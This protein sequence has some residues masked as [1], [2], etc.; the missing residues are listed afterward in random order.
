MKKI[1]KF[2]YFIFDN[3]TI[4]KLNKELQEYLNEKFTEILN[5]EARV[6]DG[7]DESYINDII[8]IFNNEKIQ[9]NETEKNKIFF[10][11]NLLLILKQ[12]NKNLIVISNF[13]SLILNPYLENDMKRLDNNLKKKN[14][15]T[16]DLFV[17]NDKNKELNLMENI[18]FIEKLKKDVESLDGNN[19]NNN[20]IIL[21]LLS[22][23]LRTNKIDLSYIEENINIDIIKKLIDIIDD[24]DSKKMVCYFLSIYYQKKNNIDYEIYWLH[25]YICY[26]YNF[27]DYF[28]YK[29]IKKI[30]FIDVNF[31]QNIKNYLLSKVNKGKIDFKN[32]VNLN[33]V[34]K[35]KLNQNF[36]LN[37]KDINLRIVEGIKVDSMDKNFLNKYYIGGNLDISKEIKIKDITEFLELKKITR[38][39]KSYGTETNMSVKSKF[40]LNLFFIYD[41][42]NKILYPR[43]KYKNT[44]LNLK[45]NLIKEGINIYYQSNKDKELKNTN[46]P[47]IIIL[48]SDILSE[49][50]ILEYF[51]I[52]NCNQIIIK[53]NENHYQI[54]NIDFGIT[55]NIYENGESYTIY[56][57][58]YEVI[59]NFEKENFW[60]KNIEGCYLLRKNNKNYILSLFLIDYTN[61][62]FTKINK[63]LTLNENNI[64]EIHR[65]DIV[66]IHYLNNH[67]IF[68][69]TNCAIY[70]YLIKCIIYNRSDI[71]LKLYDN[72]LNFV[73]RTNLDMIL[74]DFDK[75]DIDL[76]LE[77]KNDSKIILS[78]YKENIQYVDTS[79]FTLEDVNN[80]NIFSINAFGLFVEFMLNEDYHF[81]FKNY[82]LSLSYLLLEKINKDISTIQYHEQIIGKTEYY[83]N[84]S[85]DYLLNLKNIKLP[86]FL[87]LINIKNEVP[88]L[89]NY[90]YSSYKKN[91]LKTV[92]IL[93][94]ESNYFSNNEIYYSDNE[95]SDYI[96]KDKKAKNEISLFYN[97]IKFNLKIDLKINYKKLPDRTIFN[98]TLLD[99]YFKE[100]F[101]LNYISRKN[102]SNNI[103][104]SIED[105][106]RLLDLLDLSKLESSESK[107]Y[108]S[109]HELIENEKIYNDFIKN[110]K[111]IE[112]YQYK[113]NKNALKKKIK[114]I[115]E[116]INKEFSDLKN[117]FS[118]RNLYYNNYELNHI[119]INYN[120]FI[121]S[122]L[123]DTLINL[124][125]I[126]TL[127]R[128]L[129]IILN[130]LNLL[131]SNPNNKFIIYNLVSNCFQLK[132]K[133]NKEN[134]INF[135]RF[136]FELYFGFI[137]KKDQLNIL[138]NIEYN[139]KNDKRK[140]YQ[141]IMGQGKS[142]VIVPYLLNHI[143]NNEINKIII[144]TLQ[145]LI[146]QTK[147]KLYQVLGLY[148]N[149]LNNVQVVSD[150]HLKNLYIQNKLKN[151]KISH[152]K[153]LIIYDEIDNMSNS[154]QSDYNVII[155][156][157]EIS[158]INYR[159][160]FIRKFI[161]N[162]YIS[163]EY[164]EDRNELYKNNLI[165]NTKF[166]FYVKKYNDQI[167]KFIEKIM[168]ETFN[169][170]F[171]NLKEKIDYYKLIE[172][173]DEQLKK[174][175]IDEKE[176]ILIKRFLIRY[177]NNIIPKFINLI[178]NKDFG[179][180]VTLDPD[181]YS[182]IHH[183]KITNNFK[184]F[185]GVVPYDY[186]NT[187]TKKS[188]FN[189]IDL[190]IS[191]ISIIYFTEDIHCKLKTL[192]VS[193]LKSD[194]NTNNAINK[195]LNI[196]FETKEEK[197]FNEMFDTDEKI[198]SNYNPENLKV[199]DK[200]IL[201]KFLII[202]ICKL[203]LKFKSEQFN[204]SFNE[205]I[206]SRYSKYQ[207][208][209]T[210]TPNL[211]LPIDYTD[212]EIDDVYITEGN[213]GLIVNAVL[214][215][216]QKEKP[217]I[218]K[219][220]EFTLEYLLAILETNNYRCLIDTA[221]ILVGLDPEKI[222]N[223]IIKRNLE[224]LKNII[225]FKKGN[226]Y[227]ID[228][229]GKTLVTNDTFNKDS[230]ILFDNGSITG[231]DLKLD[232]IFGLVTVNDKLT[233]RDLSQGIYRLRGINVRQSIDYLYIG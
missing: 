51:I 137:M 154:L 56:Y 2:D 78:I 227:Q 203:I 26:C 122:H 32:Y 98:G 87:N 143:N 134:E 199:K 110:N 163:K 101:S 198:L 103:K 70:R 67:L 76:D 86:N 172:Y 9:K 184:R 157:D 124:Y 92:S 155:E 141:L 3:K 21:K 12:F 173:T 207:Y 158:L 81:I 108:R 192:I 43:K 36:Y 20:I 45:F 176:T 212:N 94:T 147:D 42:Q 196:Q 170:V 52:E 126:L 189:E 71:L 220:N 224:G 144:V 179:R 120:E 68:P 73:K 84:K 118:E 117:D 197:L 16:I 55:F 107:D 102:I 37:N 66:E 112:E 156:E 225:I 222:A 69:E 8:D 91:N 190:N 202:K 175:D 146:N 216:H 113:L 58:D 205:L 217:I 187:P 123:N 132:E 152:E 82:M 128:S 99:Y 4:L 38:D 223:D 6:F 28:D 24:D 60:I 151:K 180:D 142:T 19:F 195:I 210:G 130:D 125:K 221:G 165:E 213:N 230:F 65:K 164:K 228:K 136:I 63:N 79:I 161:F 191:L 233:W 171:N 159:I 116:T 133:L 25:Q 33:S 44:C 127:K 149:N 194:Y 75:L 77:N 162:F 35:I 53:P 201:E 153:T 49:V 59:T 97:L 74:N 140:Y 150:T 89:Y 200:Q 229:N 167:K 100:I 135:N 11:I 183:K 178:N 166:N 169:Q 182:F 83:I 18:N 214:G 160:N 115:Y 47:K 186:I 188:F 34:K 41:Y 121:K 13:Y 54:I 211:S 10:C 177:K 90:F 57:E 232:D 85:H 138:E 29:V 119:S 17:I 30:I 39:T 105:K 168:V 31:E 88:S 50:K 80:Q 185:Y 209:L 219:K 215:I 114:K 27:D 208:G 204:I 7:F 64:I 145:N 15:T 109:Y 174:L 104:Y 129:E 218:Y 23:L 72:I 1:R 40:E 106:Y 14:D 61:D 95:D 96:G 148:S 231:I 46:E 226:K 139:L 48:D 62:Y 181:L 206:S 93:D 131:K 22:Y 5:K 193:M 111:L